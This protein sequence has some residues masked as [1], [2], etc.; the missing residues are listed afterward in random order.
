M[1]NTSVSA[2]ISVMCCLLAASPA[3]S[4]EGSVSQTEFKV[5]D[6][7]LRGMG[8][9]AALG[10]RP[11][12][13]LA[14]ELQEALGLEPPA[15]ELEPEK[16]A[17]FLEKSLEIKRAA[18]GHLEVLVK[19]AKEEKDCSREQI[20][21]FLLAN[22]IG[23]HKS[24]ES[25]FAKALVRYLNHFGL[26]KFS[27]CATKVKNSFA[28][29]R[30]PP[31]VAESRL[32]LFYRKLFQLP[33]SAD[34]GELYQQ[35]RAKNLL[36][37]KRLDFAAAHKVA[38]GGHQVSYETVY[39]IE[40]QCKSLRSDLGDRLD[41]I[42]LFNAVKKKDEKD[43][44]EDMRLLKLAEYDHICWYTKVKPVEFLANVER[45]LPGVFTKF[46]QKLKRTK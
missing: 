41:I 16:L 31:T 19:L 1:P 8:A 46:A 4:S 10:P 12:S 40:Q 14:S 39:F 34:D 20:D 28:R 37:D 18:L 27:R 30:E 43:K 22:R 5:N 15:S 13:G 23:A 29:K 6:N 3:L 2:I 11:A 9:M 17:E 32:D 25:E 33:D 21:G 38:I 42:N 24:E 36:E 44:V 7:Y 45:N 35:L 26:K